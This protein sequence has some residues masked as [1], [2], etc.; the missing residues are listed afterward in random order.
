[1]TLADTIIALEDGKIIEVGSPQTLLTGT[2]YVAKLG[3]VLRDGENTIGHPH[4]EPITQVES[5]ASESPAFLPVGSE[6]DDKNDPDQKRKNGDWS[7]YGYY[8][9]S[10]GYR[11]IVLLLLCMALWVFCSEFPSTCL[12]T[13]FSFSFILCYCYFFSLSLSRR[14]IH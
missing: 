8:F 2:G 10:S 13:R 6:G 12:G 3:L 5:A 11:P 1:M 9:A 7:V 4:T 14:K